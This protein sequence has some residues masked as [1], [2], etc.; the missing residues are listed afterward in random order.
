MRP[1]CMYAVVVC[2]VPCTSSCVECCSAGTTGRCW[3]LILLL[4]LLQELLPSCHMLQ[5]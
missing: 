5:T 2:L 1:A 3:P 4:L